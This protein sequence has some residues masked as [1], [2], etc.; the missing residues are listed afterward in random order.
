MVRNYLKILGDP[1]LGNELDS[2]RFTPLVIVSLPDLS[3]IL[4]MIQCLSVDSWDVHLLGS[5]I[6]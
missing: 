6:A 4:G 1:A 5:R 2:F 3:R